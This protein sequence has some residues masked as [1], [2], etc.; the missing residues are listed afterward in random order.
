MGNTW[1][2]YLTTKFNSSGTVQWSI[3]PGNEYDGAN[4]I[5]ID[6][7]GNV[8]VTGTSYS[9]TTN[10]WGYATIKYNSMGVQQWVTRYDSLERDDE[11]LL[12]PLIAQEAYLSVVN[13]VRSNTVLRV[14]RFG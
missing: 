5:T 3:S 13:R 8:Y 14:I 11:Q 12:L 6:K 4:A 2:D 7:T 9:D 1:W 10:W